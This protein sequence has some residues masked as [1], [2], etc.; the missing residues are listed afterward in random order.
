M[1]EL[2]F[3]PA[4]PPF[5]YWLGPYSVRR[6]YDSGYTIRGNI[7][8]GILR[9]LVYK[10]ERSETWV[11]VSNGV[12]KLVDLVQRNFSGGGGISILPNGFVIKPLQN[13]PDVGWR[14]KIGQIHGAIVLRKSDGSF[15]DFSDL[16]ELEPGDAWEGPNT[17]GLEC[18]IREDGSLAC[19]WSWPTQFGEMEIEKNLR[20]KDPKLRTGFLR[21]RPNDSAGRVRVQASGHVITNRNIGYKKWSTFYVG[22]I[23]PGTW[24]CDWNCEDWV[25]SSKADIL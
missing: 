21:A 20:G 19:I 15:F 4:N 3:E 18:I 7:G 5:N 8:N 12:N 10:N 2:H 6:G 23:D 17:T 14:Q 9:T 25:K 16:N 11:V 24:K 13:E 1:E 22:F